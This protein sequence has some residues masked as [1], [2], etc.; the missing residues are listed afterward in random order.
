MVCSLWSMKSMICSPASR[1][2]F[3]W[4]MRC[5]R[6]K[7]NEHVRSFFLVI[8]YRCCCWYI[9]LELTFV[10]LQGLYAVMTRVLCPCVPKNKIQHHHPRPSLSRPVFLMYVVASPKHIDPVPPSCALSAIFPSCIL[11]AET[12]VHACSL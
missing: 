7:I 12:A 5:F 10:F 9:V 8:K 3:S 2:A 4:F 6:N 11:W 1:Q